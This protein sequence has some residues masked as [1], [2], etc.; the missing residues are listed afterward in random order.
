[1]RKRFPG[2][3]LVFIAMQTLPALAGVV[4]TPLRGSWNAS[5]ENAC[6]HVS[7]FFYLSDCSYARSRAEVAGQVLP[8][9]GPTVNP[10]YYA[11]GSPQASPDHVPEIGDGR[12][13]P[14]LSGVLRID[15]RGTPDGADDLLSGTLV[16]GPAARS[17]VANVNELAGGPAGRPPRAV[18]SW[19]S[20]R[21]V[22]APT[23]V[24]RATANAAGGFEYVIGAKGFPGRICR[25]ADPADCFPSALAP[26][27]TDGQKGEGIWA[28]PDSVGITRDAAMDGN[29]GARTEAVM[30]D[31]HCTDNRGGITCPSHNVVWRNATEP[32]PGA[33]NLSEA[34]GF[35][36]LLLRVNTDGGG[37]VLSVEAFWTQEYRIDAGPP[38]FQLAEGHDNSWQGGYFELAAAGEA[39]P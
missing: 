1:M 33:R 14:A 12:I 31:Y 6:I 27:T 25:A 38:G 5:Q 39:S 20:L 17:L 8:W 4:E 21:H 30:V 23:P 28:L 3:V 11:P 34:P 29:A 26:K 18:I 9:V 32:E 13:A 19:S 24:S 37:R 15:D 22:L 10:V 36:N 2:S 7:I 35:D 16:I